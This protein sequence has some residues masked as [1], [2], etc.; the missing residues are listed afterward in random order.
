MSDDA[1][2]QS[3]MLWERSIGASTECKPAAI[4]KAARRK[5]SKRQRK[6]EAK[7]GLINGKFDPRAE[8]IISRS[9][10]AMCGKGYRHCSACHGLT[11]IAKQISPNRPILPMAIRPGG[12][13]RPYVHDDTDEDGGTS[14]ENTARL[15]RIDNKNHTNLPE[16]P[17]IANG[18]S[19][20]KRESP[21]RSRGSPT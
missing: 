6:H 2:P 20:R 9:A 4:S 13:N 14:C 10:L 18:G 1:T 11:T 7:Q 3:A 19:P 8:R 16:S 21:L 15:P 5:E 17:N 12:A